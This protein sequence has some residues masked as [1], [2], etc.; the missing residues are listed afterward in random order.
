MLIRPIQPADNAAIATVIRTVLEEFEVPKVGTA[1]ADP[2]L[3][4]MFQTYSHPQSRYW[5]VLENGQIVGGAG[6]SKLE[7]SE[8]NICELQK[9]YFLKEARG[10]GNGEQMI[11]LCL[12][13]A[14]ELGYESCY[15]ETMPNMIG[16]Q[17]LYKKLGFEYLCNPLGNTG[18]SNCPVW[19]LLHLDK[20]V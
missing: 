17:K 13:K 5:V 4:V 15:L 7:N 10:H 16:A 20:F 9:M 19:M 18:H 2:Q 8:D 12:A 1:F 11:R 3:D 6:I 14:K